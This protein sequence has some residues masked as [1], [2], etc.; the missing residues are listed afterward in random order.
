MVDRVLL[1]NERGAGPAYFAISILAQI[2][3]SVLATLIVMGFSRWR[4]FRA[5]AGGAELAGTEN[6]IAALERLQSVSEPRDLPSSLARPWGLVETPAR[7]WPGF[8]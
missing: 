5:D 1:N 2:F 6:M 3:L 7:G 4:E 8:S